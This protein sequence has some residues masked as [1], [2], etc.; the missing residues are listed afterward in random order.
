MFSAIPAMTR[1]GHDQGGFRVVLPGTFG[2]AATVTK[3]KVPPFRIHKGTGQAYVTLDG[4]RSYLGRADSPEVKQ[5]YDRV[6]NEWLAGGRRDRSQSTGRKP[7]DTG[8]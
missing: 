8:D 1:C 5:R 6:I 4:R 2:E 3:N 7:G